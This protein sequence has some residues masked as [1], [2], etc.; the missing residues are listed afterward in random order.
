MGEI[1]SSLL[2]A[3]VGIERRKQPAKPSVS[4]LVLLDPEPLE[5]R[6][7]GTK[8]INDFPPPSRKACRKRRVDLR[9]LLVEP[10][11]FRIDIFFDVG[12]YARRCRVDHTL[13]Y[14]RQELGQPAE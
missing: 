11:K 10:I 13:D 1:Q 5:F 3:A 12:E 4:G 2:Q 9:K 14:F 6:S 7:Q 8:V